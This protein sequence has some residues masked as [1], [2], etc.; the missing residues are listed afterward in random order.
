MKYIDHSIFHYR[1]ADLVCNVKLRCLTETDPEARLQ[2]LLQKNQFE[3]ALDFASLYQLDTEV[4]RV[5][6]SCIACFNKC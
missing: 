2:R 1:N 4:F 5:I 6:F 3:E